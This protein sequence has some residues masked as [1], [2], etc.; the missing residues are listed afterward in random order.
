MNN[1][2]A[3]MS[4]P[5]QNKL[6]NETYKIWDE[7]FLI[8]V[9]FWGKHHV[10]TDNNHYVP[11]ALT[12]IQPHKILVA[13]ELRMTFPERWIESVLTIISSTVIVVIHRHRCGVESITLLQHGGETRSVRSNNV[14]DGHFTSSAK[15]FNQNTA[16]VSK[17]W[18]AWQ[19]NTIGSITR[20]FH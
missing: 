3:N 5:I 7:S 10:L 13:P 15:F 18:Y 14:F 6:V 20:R 16:I 17:L 12:Q 4:Q 1:V 11:T 19:R 2:T 8:L 9:S